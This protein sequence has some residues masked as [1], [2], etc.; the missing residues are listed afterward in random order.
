LRALILEQLKARDYEVL[1]MS[2][3]VDEWVAQALNEYDG[4]PLKSAEKGDLDLATISE[5]GKIEN[6]ASNIV[7]RLLMTCNF[8]LLWRPRRQ[9]R[10]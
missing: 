2:D 10:C 5:G 1:L 3:P 6:P 8:Y 9:V 4:K 7:S